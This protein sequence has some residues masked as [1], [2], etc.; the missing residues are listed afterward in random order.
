MPH[1][2]CPYDCVFCNQKRITG[3][4]KETTPDDVTEIIERHLSTLPEDADI[5]A[6]FF[7]GSFTGIPIAEQSSLMERVAPYINDGRID[8]IRLSTRPDYISDEILEN[9]KRYG[10]TTIEL[11]V[12]SMDEDVLRASN[13]GHS[14][15]QVRK[16]CEMIHSYGFRL[17]VQQMTGLPLDTDEKSV[18]TARELIA[19]NPSCVRIYPTLTIKDTALKTLYE[20]GSYIPQTV[21]EAVRLCAKLVLMYEESGVDVIRV[22]LQP[23]E[24]INDHA[25]VVAGPFHPAFGELVESEIYYGIITSHT[26]DGDI[27]IHVDPRE[28]SKVCGNRR[29][30]IERLKKEYGV[31]AF[32]KGDSN[33]K[34]RE[35]RLIAV[36]TT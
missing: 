17:G 8:G 26:I 34:K 24:E 2:G 31:N 14:A 29:R 32:V 9:L 1:K 7:G 23:T 30:N 19:L 4:I 5:E 25:S 16:A 21:D 3:Q 11:G 13:R 35:V 20:N 27:E 22:G 28:I 15:E 18:E 36:K 6:A 33:L 10:V 12:Q